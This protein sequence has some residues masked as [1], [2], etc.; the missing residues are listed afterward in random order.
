MAKQKITD[1]TEQKRLNDAREAGIPW[2]KW[3]PYLSERQWGTVREDYSENGDAWN[4]FTHDQARS[5]A[6]RW[7][8]DGLAGFSDGR[9][10]PPLLLD[11]KNRTFT[12]SLLCPELLLQELL[13]EPDEH[14]QEVREALSVLAAQRDNRDRLCEICDLVESVCT[15]PELVEDLAREVVYLLIELI[16]HS[17]ILRGNRL[18]EDPILSMA[19]ARNQV[20]LVRRNDERGLELL[21]DVDRFHGLRFQAFVDVY[22]E[23]RQI[24][25]RTASGPEGDK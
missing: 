16:G 3:G 14:Q 5:R 25:Q 17:G 7:G 19:P 12:R 24:S 6:Y 8:E 21:Q 22:Y 18:R 2:K 11:L 9:S 1:V 4:F 23:D 13:R 20:N 10:Y 15:E